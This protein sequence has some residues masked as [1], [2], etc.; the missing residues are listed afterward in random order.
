MYFY[1]IVYDRFLNPGDYNQSYLYILH[2]I[3]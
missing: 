1:D 2:L 3:K